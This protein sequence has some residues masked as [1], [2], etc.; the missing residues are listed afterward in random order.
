MKKIVLMLS[1][2]LMISLFLVGCVSEVT[3]EGA[4]AGDDEGGPIKNKT[5]VDDE[6]ASEDY[7]CEASCI[8]KTVVLLIDADISEGIDDS[9]DQFARD[10]R[11]DGYDVI[12]KISTMQTPEEIRGYLAQLHETD[13]DLAG[14]FLI[15]DIPLPYYRLY[16]P[17]DGCPERGPEEYISFQFYQDLDGDYARLNPDDCYNS[18]CYDSHTGK[19][20]SEIWVSVLPFA[21]DTADTIE[22]INQYFQKNHEYRS[23][24]NRPKQGYLR[25]LIGSRIDTI[26]QYDNQLVYLID[27]EYAWKPLTVRGNV[28]VFIDNSIGYPDAADGYEALLSGDYDFTDVG[29]H[30]TATSLG[31][32]VGSIT[33]TTDWVNAHG[34]KSTFLWS[35]SCNNGDIGFYDKKTGERKQSL[36]AEFGYSNSSV[37]LA[38]GATGGAGGLGTNIN[39]N[40]RPNIG[41]SLADGKSM[42]EAFLDHVNA[43]FKEGCDS[44]QREY[45]V[46]PTIFIGDMTLRL[47]E[48]MR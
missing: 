9:V 39:G 7:I 3:D 48:N 38:A 29:A 8:N 25:P 41:Q 23:G 14:A 45:F 24:I 35:T 2:L 18:G 11:H 27:S 28:D 21:I 16:Y 34:I 37:L 20:D 1:A 47:Q 42:G 15:G 17:G 31:A 13:P 12:T 32:P 40:F 4:A 44:Q 6:S 5:V 26:E 30:G 10:L 22:K 46:T 33:V 36:L 19:I 43:P